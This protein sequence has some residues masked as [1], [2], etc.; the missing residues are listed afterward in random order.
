MS[1]TPPLV[2]VVVLNF[3]GM[4]VLG[5]CL[6][7]L[8]A[9]DYPNV[10]ILLCDNGSTDGSPEW[11]DAH[12]DGIAIIRNK[13]NLGWSAGN[14]VGIRMA[15]QQDADYIWILNNDVEM[16]TN[17]ISVL[18]RGMEEMPSLGISS[19]YIYY[20]EPPDVPWFTGGEI[21]P[22]KLDG[23]HC[24]LEMFKALPNEKRFISGCAM[25]VR[26]SVFERIGLID[27]RFFA[28][29]EDVDFCFRASRSGFEMRIEED[30]LLYHKVG[31]S[32]GGK[33]GSP[34]QTYHILR[35]GLLFWRKH[36]GWWKFHWE[37]CPRQLGRSVLPLPEMWQDPEKAAH[38]D[39]VADALWYYLTL[40]RHPMSWPHSPRWFKW[41]LRRSPWRVVWVMSFGH[42]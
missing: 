37:Y 18:V 21:D 10:Q 31:S 4:K 15:I 27:E 28:Y 2:V 14:N 22:E 42:T 17:C 35:S 16:S 6:R 12:V 25:F 36:L 5:P 26:R 11:A 33:K 1:T 34:F 8:V 38:A 24:P 9:Q 20:H 3:N 19:P 23:S 29:C 30:A 13:R 41:M 7:D 40:R 32:S 39:A